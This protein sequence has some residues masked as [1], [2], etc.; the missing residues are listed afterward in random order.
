LLSVLSA[1]RL[2][3]TVGTGRWPFPWRRVLLFGLV[4]GLA[5]ASKHNAALVVA[6]LFAAIAV[7]KLR[8]QDGRAL[9]QLATAAGVTITIFLALNPAWWVSPWNAAAE[10]MRLRADLMRMQT[11]VFGG[12][13]SA[14]AAANGF[15]R[16]AVI[17]TPQ[18]FEV[19]FWQEL[20]PSIAAYRSSP[21]VL[22]EL[23]NTLRAVATTVL[24]AMG[25]V[26]LSRRRDPVAWVAG[27]WIA[28]VIAATLVLTPLPWAR[29]YLPA[30]PAIYALAATGIGAVA[31]PRRDA[32]GFSTPSQTTR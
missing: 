25:I 4:A 6:P 15:V 18:Y 28:G 1:M 24:A 3:A 20:G 30:L 19:P 9:A 12:Y 5:G 21:W 16:Y 2:C 23:L 27:A 13:P 14:S 29:Y 10:T 11:S 32:S 26:M 8:Q 17:E 7:W 22:P 31:W